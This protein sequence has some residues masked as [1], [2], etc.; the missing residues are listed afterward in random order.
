MEET[1][2]IV[3]KEKVEKVLANISMAPSGINFTE[4]GPYEFVIEE[5]GEDIFI[6][7]SFWRPDTQ[8]G[9]YGQGYGRLW[10]IESSNEKAIVM[11]A[12]LAVQQIIEHELLESFMYKGAR[13]FDPHKSLEDLAYPKKFK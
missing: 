3:S 9:E 8:T 11:T 5:K 13:L 2:V 7:C 12:W 1:Q 6:R 10:P 4:Q